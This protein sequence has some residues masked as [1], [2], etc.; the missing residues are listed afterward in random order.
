MEGEDKTR[1]R[2][3]LYDLGDTFETRNGILTVVDRT[4]VQRKDKVFRKH[5]TLQCEKGHQYGVKEEYL[6]SGRL[7]TC[8]KCSHPTIMEADPEFAA[9]FVDQA[10]PHERPCGCHDKADFY[11]QQCGKIVK[12]KSINNVH[13]RRQVPCPYCQN[14]VSYPERY[15]IAL[16]EQMQIPF[17]HQYSV[18]FT[19]HGQ[20]TYYKFDFYDRERGL[21]IEAHGLQHYKPG[22]FERFG[23]HTLEEIQRI[24][25]EKARYATRALHLDYVELDCRQSD[26]N[27]IRRE[28]IKKLTVYPLDTVDWDAVRQGANKSVILQI[29]EL[30]K[31]GY[32]QHQIGEIVHMCASTVCS[33]LQKAQ[34]DGIYD[35]ITPRRLRTEENKRLQKE[36]R[37]RIRQE[38]EEREAQRHAEQT[39]RAEAARKDWESKL[40]SLSPGITAMKSDKSNDTRSTFLCGACGREFTRSSAAMLKNSNC[41]WCQK[42]E[43]LRQR[44]LKTYGDEYE[45]LSSYTDCRTPLEIRHKVCG[46]VFRRTSGELTKHG[47][48][49]CAKRRRIEKSSA[50]RRNGGTEKFFALLPEFERRGYPYAGGPFQGL[51]KRNAF[52]CSHCGELW[53]TTANSILSGRDHICISPCRKKT[54]EEF[55]RQVYELVGDEY[56]VQGEYRTA[57]TPVKLRHNICGLEY[58]VAP[59]HF[60]S[61]GRRCPVCTK[62]G[63]ARDGEDQRAL[64]DRKQVLYADWERTLQSEEKGQ[65]RFLNFIW[66]RKCADVET[67][68]SQHGHSDVP[69]GHMVRDYDLG[70]WLGDQRKLYSRGRLSA[71]RVQRLEALGVKWNCKE[72][73]WHRIYEEVRKYL[74]EYGCVRLSKDSTKEERKYYYWIQDQMKRG[75]KGRVSAEKT[76]LLRA[77]GIEFDYCA[78]IRFDAMYNKLRRFVEENGHGIVPLDEDKGEDE[79]LGLWAQ[80][81]RQQMIAG[82]L[83]A[84][85]AARLTQLGLPDNNQRAKFQRKLI[86][87]T[88]Y[89]QEHGHLRIPQSYTEN[90]DK[91]GKWIN[92]FRVYYA[93]GRLAAEQVAALEAIGMVWREDAK[94]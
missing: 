76:A 35:G 69:H 73:Y 56:S 48:P 5:Y 20:N 44:L 78:D 46:E 22:V 91:L 4:R 19:Q 53:W 1:H 90:G 6:K 13:K 54:P 50:S 27:W 72:D 37:E 41:P 31:Q 66:D 87:L 32:T 21:V 11:C 84:D 92:T 59:V 94:R 83:S 34:E 33:K 77:I 29:I 64:L 80:R 17:I 8:K 85:R 65:T 74:R 57:F 28:A 14:G 40:H 2:P 75:R 42:L 55:V 9:W 70:Q 23:G 38:R 52:W 79:P 43:E 81:M 24:D 7:R 45:I 68:R 86:R 18:K 47:C 88:A 36:K 16:L 63:T 71:D 93:K 3:Y 62:V 12:G 67:F 25:A 58:F 60:T 30:S 49:A 10:I 15:V 39:E 51:G 26:P 82:T 61:T 89:R